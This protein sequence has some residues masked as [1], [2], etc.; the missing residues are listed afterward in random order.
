MHQRTG[1]FRCDAEVGGARQH[2]VA[3][4]T[5]EKIQ[6]LVTGP[7]AQQPEA[8]GASDNAFQEFGTSTAE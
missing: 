8:Q 5:G 1:H 4:R 2:A 6:L 3:G 7:P